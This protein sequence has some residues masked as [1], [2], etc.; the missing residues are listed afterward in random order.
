MFVLTDPLRPVGPR[1]P[2]R[3]GPGLPVRLGLGL[4]VRLPEFLESVDWM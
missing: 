3:L 1:L 4:P 2:V